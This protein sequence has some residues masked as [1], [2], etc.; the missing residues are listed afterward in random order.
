M[1]N[2]IARDL[3]KKVYLP[4]KIYFKTVSKLKKEIRTTEK[5]WGIITNIKHP[6]IKGKET[7]VKETLKNPNF[8]RRSK[9]NKNV[10]LF[11]KKQNQYFLCVIVKH[12][13]KHGFIITVYLTTKIIE[14]E[15]IWPIK[16]KLKK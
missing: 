9:S 3:V 2:L 1:T 14:G 6:S 5:Y 13:N 12:L 16:K 4:S 15:L 11:Y 10:Y 7:A 8:I